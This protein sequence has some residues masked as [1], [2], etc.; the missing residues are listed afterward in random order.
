M[1]KDINK[2][3]SEWASKI[4]DYEFVGKL[5]LTKDEY[6]HYSS[7][8]CNKCIIQRSD[9]P[10]LYWS[11]YKNVLVVL[12]VNC[13]YFEYDD[14]GFWVHFL[15]RIGLADR[16]DLQGNI[17]S[18]IEDYLFT[19]HFL[20]KKKEGPFRYV[21]AI[22]EQCG[23]TRRYLPRFAEFLKS[24][25][26]KYSWEGLIIISKFSYEQLLPEEGMSSYFRKLLAYTAGGE[27]VKNFA[28]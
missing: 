5:A 13:A 23:V 28:R 26:D 16:N 6:E 27:L 4:A 25:A 7:I 15:S 12:A 9:S 18:I 19:N 20:D 24:G 21:G 11:P 1:H 14:D 3:E 22:L 8:S 2:L 10:S 17:G